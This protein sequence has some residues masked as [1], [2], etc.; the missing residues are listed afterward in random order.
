MQGEG[1]T[2]VVI[3]RSSTGY[4]Q[5]R[6]KGSVYCTHPLPRRHSSAQAI[7]LPPAVG[8]RLA[9]PIRPQPED[10]PTADVIRLMLMRSGCLA[11]QPAR[12]LTCRLGRSRFGLTQ[13]D[14]IRR[15]GRSAPRWGMDPAKARFLALEVPPILGRPTRRHLSDVDPGSVSW[16]KS[17]LAQGWTQP[18]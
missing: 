4:A 6:A 8:V 16:C 10:G 13:P 18:N 1:L 14:A 7:Q 11:C 5:H 15:S 2:L 3:P 12:R 17:W 9:D